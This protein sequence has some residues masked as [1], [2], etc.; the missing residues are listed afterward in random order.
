[1][2]K[3]RKLKTGQIESAMAL[4]SNAIAEMRSLGIDQWDEIYPAVA[5]IAGD[6]VAGH[7]FGLFEGNELAGYVALNENESPEYEGVPWKHADGKRLIIHRLCVDPKFQGKGNAKKMLF[8]AER[9]DA[10]NGYALIRLDAFLRNRAALN[11][12][13]TN[14]YVLCGTVRFRKGEFNCYEKKLSL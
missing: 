5:D 10:E 1:M 2:S 4:V 6:I 3:I 13:E 7:A 11:L 8:F 14:D 9:H 12:Y